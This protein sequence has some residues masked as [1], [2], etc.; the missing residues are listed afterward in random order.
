MEDA[1][2]DCLIDENTGKWDAGML[3]GILVPTE[4]TITKKI[5]LARNPT[6]DS[7]F[8][9]L[10]ANGQYNCKSRYRFLKDLEAESEEDTKPDLDRNFW[11]C[12]WSLEVPSK[13]KNMVWRACRNSLPTKL[14][15]T[16][17]QS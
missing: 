3:E 1:T 16:K 17:K 6:E 12:I 8:W 5:P 11:K 9:P 14:N 10:T 15:L 2:V 13:Y 4:A 7:L